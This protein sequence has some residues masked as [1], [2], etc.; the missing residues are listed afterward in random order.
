[1]CALPALPLLNFLCSS[2]PP[3]KKCYFSTAC[4][5]QH[6]FLGSTGPASAVLVYGVLPNELCYAWR[7]SSSPAPHG[8]SLVRASRQLLGHTDLVV[9]CAHCPRG[10][11]Q[12]VKP[13]L[14]SWR[15]SWKPLGWWESDPGLGWKSLWGV[16][17]SFATILKVACE[18]AKCPSTVTAFSSR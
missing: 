7:A 12:R 11:K 16:Q 2:M 15:G 3:T 9:G 14:S 8:S 5:K 17:V 10:W 1:M 13:G 6:L 18:E 4:N